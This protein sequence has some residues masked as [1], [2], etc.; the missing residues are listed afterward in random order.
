MPNHLAGVHA[1]GGEVCKK[2]WGSQ[3]KELD[4]G[5]GKEPYSLQ[6]TFKGGNRQD[7]AVWNSIS[8]SPDTG[9]RP[10]PCLALTKAGSTVEQTQGGG[11]QAGPRSSQG[12]GPLGV[13]STLAFLFASLRDHTPRENPRNGT[14]AANIPRN[15]RFLLITAC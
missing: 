2:Y 7:D 9:Q 11:V 1:K 8:A 13:N 15:S 12:E 10:T 14:K 3:C 4:V 5:K 6:N